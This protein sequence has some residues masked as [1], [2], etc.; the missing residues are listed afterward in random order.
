MNDNMA[1]IY[2]Y[3]STELDKEQLS[4]ALYGTDHHW[5]YVEEKIEP[6]NCN[7]ETE[8]ISVFVTSTVSREVIEA[9]P[10]LRLIACRS[11]GFNNIDFEAANERGIAVVNVPTYGDATVAEYAFA[12]LLALQR[13]LPSVIEAENGQFSQEQLRGHDLHGKTFGVIGT[14]HIGQKALEIACGFSMQ[15]LAYDVHQ[16]SA[17]ASLKNFQYV[18]LDHLLETADVVSLH[19]P[20]MPATHH[21]LNHER[22]QKMKPGAILINT[23]RGELIDKCVDR[24]A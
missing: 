15:T 20:Y 9:L 2:F 3:D 22:L 8:V 7:P 18:D 16:D 13:K 12:M 23:A 21:I 1:L 24:G 17:L 4:G 14:G 10:K 5:E 19:V 6:A 11:T